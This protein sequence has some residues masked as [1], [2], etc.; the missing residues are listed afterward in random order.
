M[1]RALA[2]GHHVGHHHHDNGEGGG[3]V[4]QPLEVGDDIGLGSAHG[5]LKGV[6]INK[7]Q[8][9]DCNDDQPGRKKDRPVDSFRRF[10]VFI[11]IY[12]LLLF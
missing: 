6:I 1:G 2:D 7:A 11:H 9:Q 8:D 4:E 3:C 10:V 12:I 5:K